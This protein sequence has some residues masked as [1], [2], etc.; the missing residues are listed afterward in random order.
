M[1]LFAF[2]HTVFVRLSP[3]N[4]CQVNHI[5]FITVKAVKSVLPDD[6]GSFFVVISCNGIPQVSSQLSL[7][8][9]E[10]AGPFG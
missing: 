10:E 7:K 3:G 8:N 4:G 2:T 5:K 9:W 1:Y 6:G